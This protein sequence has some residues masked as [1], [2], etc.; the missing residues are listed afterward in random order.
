MIF[1]QNGIL[2]VSVLDPMRD[3]D[4]LGSRYC[5]G[6]YIWQVEDLALGPLLS[7][8]LYPGP[9]T[10]FDGQ[11]APEV[12]ETALGAD[13]AQ[14]G[15]EVCVIGVGTVKRE[16]PVTPFHVRDN[17]TVTRFADWV[18]AAGLEQVRMSTSQEFGK[19]TVELKR[20][21]TLK[22]RTVISETRLVN[23]GDRP[24]PIRW[25]AHP[26]FP[27]METLCRFSRDASMPRNPAFSIGSEG[28]VHRNPS[29]PWEKGFYQPLEMEYGS[30]LS[31]YQWHP[32]LG[33]LEVECDFPVAW[34]PLWGNAR[35]FSFE[36]FYENRVP[37][38]ASAAWSIRYH[39]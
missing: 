23:H 36:P 14:V 3:R 26:F 25:F 2:K 38:G 32:L 24:V 5:A 17:P 28:F 31:V 34:M 7:G 29:Y 13:V 12:F 15:E 20:T 22:D 9:A 10:L 37:A 8:P 11:G 18:V 30:P 35:T 19:D 39:F 33:I 16:S 21:V 6:G 1:L 4:K 27:P